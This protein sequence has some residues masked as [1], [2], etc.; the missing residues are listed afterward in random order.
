MT[1][2]RLLAKVDSEAALVLGELPNDGL[3]S[4]QA[5]S[6][7]VL[8]ALNAMSGMST[9]RFRP[10]YAVPPGAI[11]EEWLQERGVPREE[12]ALKLRRSV[13]FTGGILQGQVALRQPT[14]VTLA[15]ITGIEA[16]FWTSAERLFR[17]RAA[18][19]RL[20]PDNQTLS[21]AN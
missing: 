5:K 10:R 8:G 6:C 4:S 18:R 19:L 17:R 20:V 12:L 3:D 14:A 1:A 15:R 2:G 9:T 13:Q 11:L 21:S 7:R 16:P